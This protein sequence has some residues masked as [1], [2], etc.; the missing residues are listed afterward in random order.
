MANGLSAV[1]DLDGLDEV[2]TRLRVQGF[3]TIGP[4]RRG[5]AI[6]Y[7]EIETIGGL[8][9]GWADTQDAATYRLA[10]RDDEALF[11]YAV[12]PHSWKQ[13]LHPPREL[14]FG[15]RR[16]GGGFSIEENAELTS[17]YA[18]VG[19]RPCELAA[20]GVQDRVLCAGEHP[21]SGYSARRGE[22][23]LVAVECGEPGGSCFCVSMKTG[24]GVS[25]GFDLAL[26]ELMTGEHR[27][28]VRVGSD[29]GAALLGEVASREATSDDV[30]EARRVVEAAESRMGRLL[31][32][33]GLPA[34]LVENLQHPQ[35][36]DVA[37]RCLTCT[38]CTLVCPTCFCSTVEDL[39]SLDGQRA[40]RW[41]R[42]DSCFTLGFSALH[43]SP[44]RHSNRG[45]Y[46]QWLTHKLGT[47]WDQ[48]GESG[49]VGCGRCITWCPVGIDLTAE[50]AA[51]RR[52]LAEMPSKTEEVRS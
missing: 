2:I 30:A 39:T 1:I 52:P 27:F 23:F 24:P 16:E 28:L 13:Y 25:A 33:D 9:R 32:T 3:S 50:V 48:F 14:V 49:C 22:V 45:R 43:G 38:N 15:A 8:P 44:V 34:L 51:L 18:F 19:V 36:D 26:T 20:I 46:R 5:G 11:G 7:D 29:A 42:W 41:Q 35:W 17:R 6:V 10:R 4:T 37:R 31:D 40:E 21:D 12:G 47:W